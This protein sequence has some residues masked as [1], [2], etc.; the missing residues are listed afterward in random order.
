MSKRIKQLAWTAFS[1]LFVGVV[2]AVGASELMPASAWAAANSPIPIEAIELTP[3]PN[4]SNAYNR[5]ADSMGL[6]AKHGLIYKPGPDLSGGGPMRVQA[7]VTENTEIATS[8]IIAALG[9]IYSGG[10]VKVL[11]VMTPYGDEQIWSQNRYKTMKD[12]VGQSWAIASL[13]GAQRFNDQMAVQGMGLDPNNFKWVAIPGGDGPRLQALV[14]GRVELTTLSHI[15][16]ALAEDKGYTTKIRA[17]VPHTAKYTPPIPRLVV[18]ARPSWIEH[19]EDA[20][21]RY[22][23][24]MLEMMRQWQDHSETWVANAEKIYKSGLSKKQ[25]QTVWQEFR[26]GGYFSVNG[27][28]NYAATQKVM[29]LFFKLRKESPNEY[30]SKPSD[31]YDTGPLKKALDKMGIVKGTPGL[32]DTPDWYKK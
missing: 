27:G 32:P 9:G 22:V 30:L 29:D 2:G 23:E 3:S 5:M 10:K 24:M 18:V 1:I 11:M 15:G 8:D 16:A 17:I 4:P 31:L 21:E 20:A 25:L 7:V 14:T 12:A 19:N 26:D 13:G 28:V 6:F